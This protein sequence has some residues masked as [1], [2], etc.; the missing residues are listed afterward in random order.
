MT[1]G[2]MAPTTMVGQKTTTCAGGRCQERDGAPLKMA[3]MLAS[4]EGTAYSARVAV[5]SI[6]HLK[7]AKKA[8]R[9]A[10]EVQLQGRGLGFVEFL[11]ACPTNWHM[12]PLQANERVSKELTSYFPLGNFKDSD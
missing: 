10:F 8:L 11:S 7:K 5:D 6:A 2:Q 12:T 1:G 9:K 3:E 4:L